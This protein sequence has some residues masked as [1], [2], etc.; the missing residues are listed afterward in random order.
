MTFFPAF[1]PQTKKGTQYS[2]RGMVM[3]LAVCGPE[4]A[5]VLQI[6]LGFQAGEPAGI[7]RIWRLRDAGK[8]EYRL[9]YA[10]DLGWHARAPQYDGQSAIDDCR[11][12]NGE[13]CY[14]DGSSL[15]AGELMGIFVVEGEEGLWPKL[16]QLYERDLTNR[17]DPGI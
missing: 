2:G 14:Y 15:Q 16:E 12:L 1:P 11:F 13:A 4:G 5:V 7:E 10:S 9:P 17:A 8:C 3:S 6:D